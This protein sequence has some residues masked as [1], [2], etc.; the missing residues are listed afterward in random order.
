MEFVQCHKMCLPDLQGALVC[1]SRRDMPVCPDD[2]ITCR[3]SCAEPG[4][5]LFAV[6]FIP[7]DV[8]FSINRWCQVPPCGGNWSICIRQDRQAKMHLD[9]R[10]FVSIITESSEYLLN[11]RTFSYDERHQRDVEGAR[12]LGRTGT[13]RVG[14]VGWDEDI[15]GSQFWGTGGSRKIP[16]T[17]INWY[18]TV[19][20]RTRQKRSRIQNLGLSGITMLTLALWGLLIPI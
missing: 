4:S 18:L 19:K 15:V 16:P 13:A 14:I 20:L 17:S 2:V 11:L 1:M 7:Q 5:G 3:R 6:H 12:C 10:V 9:C 8:T